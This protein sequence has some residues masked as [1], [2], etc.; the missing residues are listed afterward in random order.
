MGNVIEFLLL[1]NL[2]DCNWIMWYAALLRLHG[3]SGG[4]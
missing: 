1:Y 4:E 2:V 3:V